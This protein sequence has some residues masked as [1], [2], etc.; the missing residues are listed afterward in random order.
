MCALG[1]ALQACSASSLLT[2]AAPSKRASN[3]TTIQRRVMIIRQ[4]HPLITAIS[5]GRL[6]RRLEIFVLDSARIRGSSRFGV[7]VISQRSQCDCDRYLS[8]M[9]VRITFETHS[10]WWHEQRRRFMPHSEMEVGVTEGQLY[11]RN[12]HSR[13]GV[14]LHD[15]ETTQCAN[16]E[17]TGGNRQEPSGLRL[18]WHA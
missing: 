8:R 11:P 12:L 5:V 9:P 7:V 1:A 2:L 3:F 14:Q 16:P 10:A 17:G 15:T 18:A 4:R 13:W 6:E